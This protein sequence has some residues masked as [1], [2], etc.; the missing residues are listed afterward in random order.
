MLVLSR[1][2]GESI[3]IGSETTIRIQRINGNSV[4]LAIEAPGWVRVLRSELLATPE[5]PPLSSDLPEQAGSFLP[6]HRKHP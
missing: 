1:K 3:A 5:G 2:V 6:L 4:R